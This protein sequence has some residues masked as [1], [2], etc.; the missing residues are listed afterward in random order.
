M[1]A[2]SSPHPKMPVDPTVRLCFRVSWFLTPSTRPMQFHLTKLSSSKCCGRAM[3]NQC[4]CFSVS[5]SFVAIFLY[6]WGS[7]GERKITI[8]T[9]MKPA[10]RTLVRKRKLQEKGRYPFS[11]HLLIGGFALVQGSLANEC[12]FSHVRK[13]V[14]RSLPRLRRLVSEWL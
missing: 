6:I 11:A 5:A 8:S 13:R 7:S 14:C 3:R 9:G 12:V 1:Y 10:I 4:G 2:P